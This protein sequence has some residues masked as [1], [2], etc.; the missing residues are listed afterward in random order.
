MLERFEEIFEEMM[1]KMNVSWYELYD[2]EAF[3][4]VDERIEA[5][6]GAEVFD[7]KEYRDWVAQMYW[8]L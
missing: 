8:D 2:S 3:D 5:E 6:F 4:L 7:T 1:E